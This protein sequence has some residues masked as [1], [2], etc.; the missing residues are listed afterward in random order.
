MSL[1]A[2]SFESARIE[3]GEKTSHIYKFVPI[4][5]EQAKPNYTAN[6]IPSG[7]VGSIVLVSNPGMNGVTPFMIVGENKFRSLT[8]S[9]L[10]R[11]LQGADSVQD[12]N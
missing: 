6:E 7:A 4:T 11:Y 9:E 3:G 2:L 10:G 5:I 1:Y 8:M 12:S